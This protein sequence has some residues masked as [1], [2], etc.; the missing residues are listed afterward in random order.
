MYHVHSASSNAQESDFRVYRSKPVK[1]SGEWI[2]FWLSKYDM[3]IRFLNS[4]PERSNRLRDAIEQFLRQNPGSPY[5]IPE[6]AISKFLSQNPDMGYD[7]L[8]LFYGKLAVSKNHE[9]LIQ[10]LAHS[11]QIHKQ[12]SNEDDSTGI[13]ATFGG[14]ADNSLLVSGDSGEK[15]VPLLNSQ[16]TDK[17]KKRTTDNSQNTARAKIVKKSFLSIAMENEERSA[18]LSKLKEYIA[19]RNYS[20]NTENH[21][22]NAVARFLNRLTPETT[23]DWSDC[24]RHY[25]I[26]LRDDQKLAASSVNQHAAAIAYFFEEV[27]D[28]H[29]GE[30]ILIR[31]KTDKA[32]PR[33]HSKERV[34]QIISTPS[35]HKHRI[36]LMLTYGCGLRL[37]E[38][39]LLRPEHIDIERRVLW[40]RKGKGKKDRMVMLDHDLIPIMSEWLSDGCGTKYI[41]EGYT[42]GAPLSKRTIEKIYTASCRKLNIDSQGGI[43]SLRHSFATHLLE[44]GTDL[45]Y[46]QELLGHASS[47]TTEIYTHVAAHK[48]L[49]I[50]S[51][52]AGLLRKGQPEPPN[53]NFS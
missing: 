26:Y 52:I 48:L 51:P 8:L 17:K 2:D 9:C 44:Q 12:P 41:F 45:R 4:T 24:F 15:T 29:P 31:M 42:A 18:L 13:A 35:N 19:V 10:K 30:D 28:V 11:A 53:T 20:H 3:M 25:L 34:A 40:I 46:I 14:N 38:V 49:E 21:Y 33:V 39:Q 22:M 5:H 23:R 50:R 43:H 32:L 7:A 36:I 1:S 47:K 27:L 37:G 16:Y 6:K